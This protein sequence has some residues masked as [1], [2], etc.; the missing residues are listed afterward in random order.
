MGKEVNE[1]TATKKMGDVELSATI[2]YDFGGDL[3]TA[4]EMFGKEIVYTNFV[5]S[6]VITAQAAMR[7]WLVDGKSQ[8]EIAEKMGNWKPGV[9]I[10][11][12]V[13][14]IAATLAKFGKMDPAAQAALLSQLQALSGK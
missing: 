12:V 4:V 6:A 13:D 8:D 3:D 5:R 2:T 1:I 10:E 7:R 14:P 11:R 9:A